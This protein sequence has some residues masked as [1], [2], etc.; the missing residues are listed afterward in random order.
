MI[1]DRAMWMKLATLREDACISA[2]YSLEVI[3]FMRDWLE[4]LASA[5]A[6]E[7]YLAMA[8]EAIQILH[9]EHELAESAIES[10]DWMPDPL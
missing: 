6:A 2:H 5:S 1:D 7:G 4:Q 9:E 8:E 3:R 10:G